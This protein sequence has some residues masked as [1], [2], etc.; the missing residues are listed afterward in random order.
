MLQK[1]ETRK[2]LLIFSRKEI[3]LIFRETSKK[4]FIFQETELSYISGKVYLEPQHIQ[5]QNHIQNYS[6]FRTRGIQNTVEYLLWNA[7]QKQLPSALS[8]I[9]RNGTFWLQYS[10]ISYIFSKEIFSY[11]PRNGK[12]EKI[13]YIFLKESFFYISGNGNPEKIPYVSGNGTFL[14]FR[15]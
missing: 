8:Y 7:S 13:S 14:Y 3:F 10:E 1:M 6:I 2:K 12:P 11:I 4:S 15:K 5:N 9:S